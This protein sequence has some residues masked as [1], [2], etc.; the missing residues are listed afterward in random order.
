MAYFEGEVPV[1]SGNNG[2]GMWGGDGAIWAILL[3]ALLGGRWGYGNNGGGGSEI[4]GYEL[5]KLSTT[6][7]VASGFSTSTIMSNQRTL[8]SSLDSGFAGVQQT[9][10]QGFNGINTSILTTSNDT[11][12]QIADCLP[13]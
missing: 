10:C 8:Q 11:Q 6:N 2:N 4:T 1:V 13:A 9:M 7:D 3:L 5:G 12:R